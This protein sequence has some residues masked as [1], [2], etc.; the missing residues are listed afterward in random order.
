MTYPMRRLTP[1]RYPGGK[2]QLAGFFSG[3]VAMNG[4]ADGVY[5]EPFAG[6]AGVGVALLLGE[7]VDSII[8]NDIDPAVFAFW[9]SVVVHNDELCELVLSTPLTV[10]EW[11]HQRSI[12]DQGMAV[13][14]LALGFAMFY[15]NRTN[16]SGILNGGIIGGKN[17]EGAWKIDARFNRDDLVTRIRRIGRYRSR[18]HVSN[19]DALKFLLKIRR[20]LPRRSLIYLDPPYYEKGQHLYTNY[21]H[22]RDHVDIAIALRDADQPWVVSYDDHRA[23]RDLYKG[24]RHTRYALGYSARERRRGSEVMFFSPNLRTP[25]SV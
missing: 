3:V 2:A 15:L 8:I 13:G 1:L 20:T 9:T 11:K 5:V 19:V 24:L 7:H 22:H 23:I 25:R 21:Y 14:K 10:E 12:Y 16:R 4:L 6:G 18:I 17:Q